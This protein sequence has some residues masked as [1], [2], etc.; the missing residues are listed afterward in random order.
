M[1]SHRKF[2]T[3]PGKKALI[4]EIS[5]CCPCKLENIFK[6]KKLIFEEDNLNEVLIQGWRMMSELKT[7]EKYIFG[8]ENNFSYQ[9]PTPL[10]ENLFNSFHLLSFW[11]KSFS[12][13]W[14]VV[15]DGKTHILDINNR[16]QSWWNHLWK[17]LKGFSFFFLGRDKKI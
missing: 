10:C 12:I 3:L 7:T 14:H 15:Y 16:C 2:P 13:M 11:N 1:Q 8:G 4:G 6:A 9:T 5:V 17:L